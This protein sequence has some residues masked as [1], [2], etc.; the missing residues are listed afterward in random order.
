VPT[1]GTILSALSASFDGEAYDREL[2]ERQR[3]TLY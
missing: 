1:P 3:N 2:P